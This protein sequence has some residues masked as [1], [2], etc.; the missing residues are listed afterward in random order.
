MEKCGKSYYIYVIMG[1][2]ESAETFQR[3]RTCCRLAHIKGDLR[4]YILP[5]VDN[6]IVHMY[7]IPHDV[8]KKTYGILVEFFCRSDHNIS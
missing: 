7:R 4:L 8:C 1:L 6:C 3:M 2:Q 5:V